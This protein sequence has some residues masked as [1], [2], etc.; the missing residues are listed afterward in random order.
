MKPNTFTPDA[1]LRALVTQYHEMD[2][3][4][5]QL[6]GIEQEIK[7]EQQRLQSTGKIDDEDSINRESACMVKLARI[8]YKRQQLTAQR[9]ALRDPISRELIRFINAISP[10]TKE[11][12]AAVKA[13]AEQHV[14]QLF[15]DAADLK[16][17]RVA[18]GMETLVDAMPAMQALQIK[19]QFLSIP[20]NDRAAREAG[21]VL[22]SYKAFLA[23]LRQFAALLP[24]DFNPLPQSAEDYEARIPVKYRTGKYDPEA[25]EKS[26]EANT[27]TAPECEQPPVELSREAQVFANARAKGHQQTINRLW[28]GLGIEDR[29]AVMEAEGIDL[30]NAGA[31]DVFLRQNM[32]AR[33]D[34]CL[35]GLRE[36]ENRMAARIEQEHQ[37]V[38]E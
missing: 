12:R 35:A 31:I 29:V 18:H 30:V 6:D 21:E 2:Q 19:V 8:P 20:N 14:A 7:D 17:S 37:Q 26:A 4:L 36:I 28:N 10:C 34:D 24:K 11:A 5:E 9:D 3:Q 22:E 16:S 32:G 25:E 38:T 23:S 13:H 33:F 1:A 15:G 27:E